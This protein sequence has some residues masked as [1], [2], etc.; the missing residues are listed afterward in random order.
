MRHHLSVIRLWLTVNFH[1][2]VRCLFFFY[3]VSPHILSKIRFTGV[4]K[5]HANLAANGAIGLVL[6]SN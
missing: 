4:T 6:E 2:N 5:N 1:P 3:S